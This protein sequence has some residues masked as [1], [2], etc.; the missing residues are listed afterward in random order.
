M[1][2][3]NKTL[4]FFLKYGALLLIPIAIIYLYLT[5]RLCQKV[6]KKNIKICL[7]IFSK[8]L[9]NSLIIKEENKINCLLKDY[10]IS[11]SESSLGEL[12]DYLSKKYHMSY[13][14]SLTLQSVVMKFLMI[15]IIN[16][17]LE[18]IYNNGYIFT[19]N[20]FDNLKKWHHLL[21]YCVIVEMDDKSYFTNV[22]KSTNNF[23]FENMIESSLYPMVKLICKNDIRDY[24]KIIFPKNVIILM[25]KGNL[26]YYID[27]RNVDIHNVYTMVDGNY[28]G[29]KGIVL[30][31]H[32]LFGDECLAMDTEEFDRFKETGS[33]RNHAHDFMALLVLSRNMTDEK[34]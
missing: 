28:Y 12:A 30:N 27:F 7:K 31:I 33:Y 16:E 25:S 23:S 13:H 24:D 4:S 17:Q 10:L 15:E 6:I 20:E 19:K 32:K 2:K 8:D 11:N 18:L 9:K 21:N 14:S 22:L 3:L 1:S 26:E 29:I 34:K 5:R